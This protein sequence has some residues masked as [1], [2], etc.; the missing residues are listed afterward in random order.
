MTLFQKRKLS[1]RHLYRLKLA[2]FDPYWLFRFV[3][4][5][6]MI[7]NPEVVIFLLFNWSTLSRWPVIVVATQ[8]EVADNRIQH[9]W[10]ILLLWSS[11][12]IILLLIL[13]VVATLLFFYIYVNYRSCM[14]KTI[15][16][17]SHVIC[18]CK[19]IT[20]HLIT[21]IKNVFKEL[22]GETVK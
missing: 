15:D 8:C 7:D 17:S 22:L 13:I 5:K 19:V 18:S 3:A 6:I 2:D 1:K 12:H 11:M 16:R 9:I 14:V 10:A 20:A 21:P 4:E